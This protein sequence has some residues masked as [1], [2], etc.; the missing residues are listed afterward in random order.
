M[1]LVAISRAW[2]AAVFL[3]ALLFPGLLLAM[4][5]L[6]AGSS[7]AVVTLAGLAGACVSYFFWVGVRA[8]ETGRRLTDWVM[9]LGLREH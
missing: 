1:L 5:L 6:P 4:L 3:G 2:L 7:D 8:N 9:R